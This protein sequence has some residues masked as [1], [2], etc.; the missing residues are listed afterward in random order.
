MKEKMAMMGK[1]AI[2][3]WGKAAP[4]C[5]EMYLTIT[6]PDKKYRWRGNTP[7]E[8]KAWSL[9]NLGPIETPPNMRISIGM[10]VNPG[11]KV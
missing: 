2:G 3:G 9:I 5:R 10:R 6:I 1:I 7:I 11:R 4:G 8:A